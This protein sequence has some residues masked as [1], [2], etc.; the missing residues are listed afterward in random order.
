[1]EVLQGDLFAPVAGRTFDRIVCHPPFEPAIKWD[2]TFSIGGEDGEAI[3]ARI[4]AESPAY[5]NAGGR[6]YCQ[7]TGTDRTGEPFEER[8]RT[9]LGDIGT[10]LDVALFVRLST[11]PREYAVEQILAENQDAWKLIEWNVMYSKIKARL[12]IVGMLVVQKPASE[13]PVFFTRR[14]FG[15]RT[16]LAE[17]EALLEWETRSVTPGFGDEILASRPVP[18]EGWKLYA[19]HAMHNGKLAT[20]GYT[21]FSEYPFETNLH[22]M[23]WMPLVVSQ[24]DGKRTAGE[25]LTAMRGR[26]RIDAGDYVQALAALVGMNVLRLG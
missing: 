18:V 20:L 16:G 13:R 1:V 6:L 4:V 21:F 25:L 8:V 12:V 23:P 3:I 11:E 17:M 26:M 22:S 24:C 10:K 19:R 7:V 5:L 9:W 2:Y 15:S 14:V